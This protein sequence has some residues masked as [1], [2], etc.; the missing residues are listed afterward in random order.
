M[1]QPPPCPSPFPFLPGPP[2]LSFPGPLG[3][4]TSADVVGGGEVVV[5]VVVTTGVLVVAGWGVGGGESA[6]A[7]TPA[8]SRASTTAPPINACFRLGRFRCGGGIGIG[9]VVLALL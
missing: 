8:R 9:A 6:K 3:C 5:V 4:S 1:R 7:R 2:F